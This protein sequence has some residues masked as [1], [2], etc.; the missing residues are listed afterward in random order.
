MRCGKSQRSIKILPELQSSPHAPIEK[1]PRVQWCGKGP[2]A[3]QESSMEKNSYPRGY[4]QYKL[5]NYTSRLTLAKGKFLLPY[6]IWRPETQLHRPLRVHWLFL[7][8]LWKVI[9]KKFIMGKKSLGIWKLKKQRMKVTGLVFCLLHPSLKPL[10]ARSGNAFDYLQKW[11]KMKALSTLHNQVLKCPYL[12]WGSAA[13][14][15]WTDSSCC[16]HQ[17]GSP[18]HPP[19]HSHIHS[20]PHD[21]FIQF[22]YLCRS[23]SVVVLQI[24]AEVK[25]GAR[26]KQS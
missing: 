12:P 6:I 5:W 15:K 23:F 4:N 26:Q 7:K 8:A 19:T 25:K 16:S 2:V 22:I 9:I 24:T 11:Q 3:Q 21:L 18:C 14:S 1:S 17:P 10:L 13:D 20:L